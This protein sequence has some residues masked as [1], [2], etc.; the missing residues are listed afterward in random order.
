MMS[1][2]MG[3]FARSNAAAA[4]CRGTASPSSRKARSAGSG[5]TESGASEDE[6]DEE[7]DDEDE[8]EEEA[9][10]EGVRAAG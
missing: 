10:D 1:A 5:R 8:D 6:D 4:A 9:D 7:E 2:D 3:S